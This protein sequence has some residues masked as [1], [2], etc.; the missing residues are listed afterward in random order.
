M[1]SRAQ[2]HSVYGPMTDGGQ[3]LRTIV[4]VLDFG[5]E[6]SCFYAPILYI[7]TI[8]LARSNLDCAVKI[9][10]VCPMK[11]IVLKKAQSKKR[12]RV[13]N[14]VPNKEKFRIM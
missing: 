12:N 7:F 11:Y 2:G 8:V 14:K 13:F 9:T 4:R 1:C 10:Y 6:L 3:A 5:T